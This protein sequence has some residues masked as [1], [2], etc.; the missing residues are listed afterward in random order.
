MTYPPIMRPCGSSYGNGSSGMQNFTNGTE[1]AAGMM[2]ALPAGTM[3]ALPTGMPTG[4]SAGPALSPGVAG[5][6]VHGNSIPVPSTVQSTMFTPGFLT[7]QIGKLMR[8]EFLIGTNGP[9]IDRVGTLI[10]VGA[11]YI[12]LR[13]TGSDDVLLC[14]IYSIKFVTILL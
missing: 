2:P 6:Q 8:V 14:D 11:S 5:Q 13:P 3:P 7:T 1:Q 4:Y 9:L 12:L 10:A